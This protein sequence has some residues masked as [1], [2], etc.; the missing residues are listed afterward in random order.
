[1]RDALVAAVQNGQLPESR[2]D[3]AAGRMMAVA[4]GDATALSC[5]QTALPAL[6]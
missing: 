5:T 2:L 1:M 6:K 3:E 4:G